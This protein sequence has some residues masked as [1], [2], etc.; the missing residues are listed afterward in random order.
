MARKSIALAMLVGGLVLGLSGPVGGGESIPFQYSPTSGPPGTVIEASGDD[1]GLS[2]L[3]EVVLVLST[4]GEGSEIASA[5]IPV[6]NEGDWSGT[7]TVPEGTPPG[8]YDLQAFCTNKPPEGVGSQA[9]D[10][11]AN[12]EFTYQPDPGPFT[13]TG[14][15]APPPTTA[16]APTAPASAAPAPVVAGTPSFTG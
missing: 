7:L 1:C 16:P 2:A 3:N 4:P 6:T 14:A 13:V 9:V 5:T 10:P 11:P 8:D 12:V 15:P